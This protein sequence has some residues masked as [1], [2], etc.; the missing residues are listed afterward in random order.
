MTGPVK[1]ILQVQ[2]FQLNWNVQT[3]LLIRNA[4]YAHF[5]VTPFVCIDIICRLRL[6]KFEPSSAGRTGLYAPKIGSALF[7]PSAHLSIIS[8]QIEITA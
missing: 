2:N 8:S 3:R 5:R 4:V 6:D 1:V 7:V